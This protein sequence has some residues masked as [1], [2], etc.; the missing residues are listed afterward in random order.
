M[1]RMFLLGA[2]LTLLAGAAYADDQ[3]PAMSDGA[4]DVPA[5]AAP[6]AGMQPPPA[7]PGGM[8]GPGWSHYG[9]HR[10]GMGAGRHPWMGRMMPPGPPQPPS[11]AAHFVFEGRAGR[12]DIKCAEGDSTQSC[13]EAVARLITAIAPA[14]HP[15]AYQAEPEAA[16]AQ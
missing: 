12:I 14:L 13:A 9:F 16:P 2:A 11:K 5:A 7:P 1:K 4:A 3:T 8:M 10:P 15:D 6:D